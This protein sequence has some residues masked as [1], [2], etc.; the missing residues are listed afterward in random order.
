MA[1][2]QNGKN[3]W[4]NLNVALLGLIS[5]FGDLSYELITSLLPAFLATMGAGAAI[6]GM[7]EGISDGVSSFVKILS[8]YLS[9]RFRKRKE[10]AAVGYWL[11]CAFSVS[12][13]FATSPFMILIGRTVAWFGKGIR[14]PARDALL[15]AS[16]DKKDLGKAFGFHRAGDTAGAILGPL[17]GILLIVSLTFQQAFLIA[18]IPAVTAALLFTFFVK[19]KKENATVNQAAKPKTELS[20]S[21]IPPNYKTYLAAI[22]VFGLADFSH[23]LLVLRATQLLSPSM[24]IAGAAAA[25]AGLYAFRNV[26]YAG[27]S[28]PLGALSDKI[29]RK[30]L[31]GASYV[32]AVLVFIGFMFAG[33]DLV[34]LAV[35]FGLAGL[36]I[37]AED[38]L[39]SAAAADLLPDS[40][41][42]TG[43]GLLG[44][45]N[46]IGDMVSSIVVGAL[47]AGVSPLAA[48]AYSAV[49]G[50]AGA[51]M[52][53]FTKWENRRG[54]VPT[55]I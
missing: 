3:S 34:M 32:L 46:G 48:F 28:Y 2:R 52:M 33:P 26:I 19:E 1:V 53:L 4:L 45:A 14:G 5:F 13:A 22:T 49:V 50:S 47:W 29:G 16:V 51:L 54:R 36:Y 24:G 20:L 17:L 18:I 10:V 6:L 23:T 38:T 41:K 44:A 55:A 25:A 15:A 43:F 35:L 7:I 40:L 12:V 30:L 42:A 31:I 11:N 27:A 9:D 8:G 37:A 21:G 39:E